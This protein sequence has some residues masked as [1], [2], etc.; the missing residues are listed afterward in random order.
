MNW[1]ESTFTSQLAVASH[2]SHFI[3]IHFNSLNAVAQQP[4]VAAL[5]GSVAKS[6]YNIYY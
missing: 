6:T 4:R 3:F 1:N 5:Q 2:E